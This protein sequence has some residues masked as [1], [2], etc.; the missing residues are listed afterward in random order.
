MTMVSWMLV[1]GIAVFFV[2]LGMRL[3]PTYIENYSVKQVLQAVKQD[4]QARDWSPGQIKDSIIKRLKIN[5][6]YDFD[7]KWI[8]VKKDKGRVRIEVNYEVRKNMV[9][10][11]DA[12]MSFQEQVEL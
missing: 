9:G 2:V 7:R 8:T 3:I 4:R 10:N 6:V 5:S 11:I 12:V 1:I